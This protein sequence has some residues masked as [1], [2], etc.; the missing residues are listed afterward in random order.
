MWS[1]KRNNGK[2]Q[3]F[4]RYTDEVTGLQ[5]TVSITLD[6]N[7]TATRK[8]AQTVLAALIE[9]KQIKAGEYANM[10]L[11]ELLELYLKRDGIRE[12][13]RMRDTALSNVIKPILGG[14]AKINRINAGYIKR[15]LAE[16]DKADNAELIARI[17]ALMRW[18][19]QNDYVND[20][21]YLGK[22]KKPKK[23]DHDLKAKYLEEDELKTLLAGMKIREWR[24]LTEFLVLSGLRIG[25]AMDLKQC[26]IDKDVIHVNS[27]LGLLTHESGPTKTQAGIR[28]VTIT[29]QLARC[30]RKIRKRT[31]VSEK[32]LLGPGGRPVDY[33]AYRKYLAE[34]SERI[35][36]RRITPHALR[37]SYT[38]HMAAAGI[39]LDV[40]ARQLGH[41]DS[42]VTRRVYFHVTEKL[43]ER[44]A[45][46]ILKAARL[47]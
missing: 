38:S 33:A 15:K 10:T 22:L 30:I 20:I 24:E 27:T 8:A 45:K 9:K 47:S 28:D 3:F 18:A 16:A 14:E 36:G 40:I 41:E 29:P 17:K 7:T 6:R 5:H 11:E 25:E 31:F 32:F 19:Y 23:R 42:S 21:A 44:D 4:E 39:P 26:D 46:I 13:T 12:S 2:W 43:K 35:L 1:Q 37:H 34:N